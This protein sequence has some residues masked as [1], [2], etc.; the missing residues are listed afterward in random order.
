MPETIDFT[1]INFQDADELGAFEPELAARELLGYALEAGASD[2]FITDEASY[3]SI[4]MRRMGRVEPLQKLSREAGR[5]LQNHFRAVGGAD[6][7]DHIKPVEGRK[8]LEI[9]DDRSVDIRISALPN[10]FGQDLAL[11]LF[12]GDQSLLQLENLGMLPGELVA[13]RDLLQASSGLVL[14]SGP[15]DSGKTSSLYAFLR[16]L[17]RG[18]R[19]I[20]T[21]EDPVE[22][23]LPGIVQSQVNVRA[24]VGYEQL[25]YSVLRHAPDMIMIGEI[26]DRRTAEIAVQAGGSGQLVLASIHARTAI[27]AL[28]TMAA[29]GV[30]RHFLA[31]SLRGVVSQRLIRRLCR[32]CRFELDVSDIDGYLDDLGDWLPRTHRDSL[33]LP[34]GCDYCVE[35]YDQLTCI[36]EILKINRR[37]RRAIADE[38]DFDRVEQM[39]RQAGMAPFR[40]AAQLRL[41]SGDTTVEEVIREIPDEEPSERDPVERQIG[42]NE[43]STKCRAVA[44]S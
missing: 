19:K 35:G 6:V 41:A 43:R 31:N 26:R 39:A 11:R 10:V 4:R 2:V 5:R 25:L 28:Q 33:F 16:Y 34:V 22:F 17:N 27:G 12:N 20:H 29:H 30:N 9:D 37:L 14:V 32:R 38:V 40:T 3:V 13:I 1:E 8:L 36:P 24:G 42:S 44:A 21:I 23:T 18:D 15:T 7:T